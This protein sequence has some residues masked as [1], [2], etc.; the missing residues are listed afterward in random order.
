MESSKQSNGKAVTELD[1]GKA[2][3]RSRKEG[4]RRHKGRE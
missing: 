3:K 4:S 2:E 1:P